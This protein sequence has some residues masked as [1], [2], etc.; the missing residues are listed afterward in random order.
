MNHAS[1]SRRNFIKATGVAGGAVLLSGS[2]GLDDP[3]AATPGEAE[4]FDPDLADVSDIHVHAAPDVGLRLINELSFATDAKKAGYRAVMFKSN[5]W[6]CHDRA[7]LVRE[8][9]SDFECFG[10]L[11]MN[12]AHGEKVNVHAAEKAVV[13]T[14]KLCRCIWMP[15]QAAEYQVRLEK[16][17]WKSIPVLSATGNV[18]PEVVRVM[19]ICAEA[20]IIFATGHSSPEENIIMAKRAREVGVKKFVATHA[21]SRIWRMTKEQIMTVADLGGYIEYSYIS[22]LWGP[23]TGLP[24]FERRSNEDFIAYAQIVPEQSF[25]S[26]DMGQVGLPHPVEAMRICIRA[27]REG[28]VPQKDIDMMV[29]ANPAKLVGLTA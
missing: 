4:I 18:L 16:K 17:P 2:V 25:I 5:E 12:L 9:L 28:G 24:H 13:T 10:S 22:C 11:C 27:M 26:T 23:G 7:F 1:L 3:L 15:T 29:R 6:S 21:N 19:E 8:A 14:G 20:D